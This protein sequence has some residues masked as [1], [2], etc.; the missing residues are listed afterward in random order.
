[1]GDTRITMVRVPGYADKHG[2]PDRFRITFS[3]PFLSFSL[4]LLVAQ[5]CSIGVTVTGRHTSNYSIL[6]HVSIGLLLVVQPDREAGGD[7]FLQ[8]RATS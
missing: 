8:K 1:M 4:S 3:S 2:D 7:P 5:R 6:K